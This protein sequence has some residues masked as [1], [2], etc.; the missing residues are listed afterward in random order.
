MKPFK[1]NELKNERLK[2]TRGVSFQE[3]VKS[4]YIRTVEHPQ[5]TNQ[6]VMLFE[7]KDYVWAVPFVEQE[8]EIFL[9]TAYPS[10]KHTKLYRRGF[11]EK[12]KD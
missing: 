7:Y 11:Y 5:R 3:I 8:N 1:W 6:E 10:R 2:L 12:K 4:K 9:K